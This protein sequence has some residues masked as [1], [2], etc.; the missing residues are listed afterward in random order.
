[1]LAQLLDRLG[2]P[3]PSAAA[4]PV[5]AM[6]DGLMY[7]RVAGVGASLSEEE[8]ETGVRRTVTALL[9]ALSG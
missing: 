2:V 8:F 7:D 4:W 6:L 5:A 1:M 3:N 9:D